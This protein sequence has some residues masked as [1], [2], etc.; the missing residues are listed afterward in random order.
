M[1]SGCLLGVFFS[2]LIPR[3]LYK[4]LSFFWNPDGINFLFGLGVYPL[5]QFICCY[6][7]LTVFLT[8]NHLPGSTFAICTKGALPLLSATNPNS[9]GCP[10]SEQCSRA[11]THPNGSLQIVLASTHSVLLNIF[12]TT[13]QSRTGQRNLPFLE[14]LEMKPCQEF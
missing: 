11:V 2:L 1:F 9:L 12:D 6:K 7:S 8:R 10:S 3:D 4:S 14:H 13:L 5:L